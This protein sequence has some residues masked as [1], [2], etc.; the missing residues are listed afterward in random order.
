MDETALPND[1]TTS[2]DGNTL[3]GCDIETISP[4]GIVYQPDHFDIN[5][6]LQ[7]LPNSGHPSFLYMSDLNSTYN[8]VAIGFEGN[9]SAKS[10]T[11]ITNQTLPKVAQQTICYLSL[12]PQRFR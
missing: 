1:S 5:L 10:A 3:S 2:N 11:G 8:H 7:N 9:I 12:M 6:I 4:I